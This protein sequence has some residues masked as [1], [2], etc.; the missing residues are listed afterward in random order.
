MNHSANNTICLNSLK[1][2]TASSVT[3]SSGSKVIV[4]MSTG[5]SSGTKRECEIS[6]KETDLENKDNILI[7]SLKLIPSY[8]LKGLAESRPLH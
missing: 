1:K 6:G 4:S 5:D 8:Q 2:Q 7:V 3:S